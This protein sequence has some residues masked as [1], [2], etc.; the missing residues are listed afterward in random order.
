MID[1]G[2]GTVLSAFVLFCRI[3]GCLMLMPGFSSPRV[4]V[5]IRLLIALAVTLA[6]TP[7]LVGEAG[8][9]LPNSSLSTVLPVVVSELLIG[10]MIGLLGRIFMLA[11]QT[12]STAVAMSIGFGNMFG[13]P[14]EDFEPAAPLVSLITFSATVLIF[15]TD[16]HWEIFRALAASY[17]ALPVTEGFRAQFSLVQVADS[18]SDAFYLALRL[19]APFIIYSVIVNLAIGLTNKLTPQI[20]IYFISLPFVL[21]GGLFLLYFTIGEYL[22]LFIAGFSS[23]L[24]GS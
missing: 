12:L 18:L 10:M 15:L 11:L 6:L 22:Q 13:A 3:G 16:Q 4:P 20:P 24:V 5:N 21:A 1:L 2:P 7:L 19:S 23:W 9:A 8:R 17:A 14:I